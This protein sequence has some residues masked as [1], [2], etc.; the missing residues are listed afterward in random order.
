M[1]TSNVSNGTVVI[2]ADSRNELTT[3]LLKEHKKFESGKIGFI[4][5]EGKWQYV[6]P[7]GRR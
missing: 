5:D 3:Y 6:L 7:I 4:P 2:K 1:I